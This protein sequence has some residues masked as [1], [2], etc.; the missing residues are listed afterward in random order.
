LDGRVLFGSDNWEGGGGF[1]M[2]TNYLRT[3]CPK[4]G[5]FSF[6]F[7]FSS[8]MKNSRSWF[9]AEAKQWGGLKSPSM[10]IRDLIP[11]KCGVEGGLPRR[12]GARRPPADKWTTRPTMPPPRSRQRRMP[13]AREISIKPGPIS[14]TGRTTSA[15]VLAGQR[16]TRVIRQPGPRPA[17]FGP[18]AARGQG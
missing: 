6:F 7:F 4:V 16:W 13:R 14:G 8:E 3:N 12:A 1:Q 5:I 15:P 10:G 18:E 2:V 11:E 9:S 17:G